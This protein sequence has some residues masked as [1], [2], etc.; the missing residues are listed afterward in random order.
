[1]I[2]PPLA[3]LLPY[4]SGQSIRNLGPL[5]RP[6]PLHVFFHGSIFFG[7]PGAF[8]EGGLEDF[9]PAMKALYFSATGEIL[10]NGFPVFG[11]VLFYG[12]TECFVLNNVRCENHGERMC[13]E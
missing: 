8:D 13:V 6:V 7:G 5:A 2:V 10:G 12:A 11:S 3:T 1:M 4:P 9:L